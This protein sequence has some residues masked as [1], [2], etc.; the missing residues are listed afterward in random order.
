MPKAEWG[1]RHSC[2]ACSARFYDFNRSPPCCP[3][4]GAI[5]ALEDSA[6]PPVVEDDDAT[7]DDD[8]A[9][10]TIETDDDVEGEEDPEIED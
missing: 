10:V 1:T 5:A 7:H 2:T 4:C 8:G 6:P 3:C 9:D